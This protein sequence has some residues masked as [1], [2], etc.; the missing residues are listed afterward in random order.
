MTQSTLW[1][2][3]QF[4]KGY[5]KDRLEAAQWV[6][7]RPHTFEQLLEYSFRS[8]DRDSYKASWVLEFVC[9]EQLSLLYPK[10]SYFLEEL[11]SVTLDQSL[12]P[13]S[14][15]CELLC[16]ANYKQKDLALQ[17]VFTEVHKK[18]MATCCF[19]WLI[20][21]QKV[22]CQVR[23]MTSLYYLGTEFKWI[24]P[25]L[26]HIVRTKMPTGS[27]GYKARGKKTLQKIESGKF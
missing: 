25:E 4:Q 18:Q 14:H 3:L 21:P 10:L 23:A 6:L 7:D 1:Q 5:R 20:T 17:A 24:H 2:Q 11:P 13:F 16:L 27:A 26:A 19:D 12:R 22:A 9:L 8:E 15:I